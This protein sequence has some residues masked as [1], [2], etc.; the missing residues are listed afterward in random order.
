MPDVPRG[1][2]GKGIMK[3]SYWNWLANNSES[4]D[5]LNR[6]KKYD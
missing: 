4:S 2:T 5:E 3:I 1:E 6:G